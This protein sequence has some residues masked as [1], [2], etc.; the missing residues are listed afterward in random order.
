[1]ITIVPATSLDSATIAQLWNAKRLDT[2]SCWYQAEE[3]DSTYIEALLLAG[4][5]MAIAL[6]DDVPA[7]FGLWFASAGEARLVALAADDEAVYYRLM[8]E[9]CDWAQSLGAQE[10][11]AEIGTEPTSE[12]ARMDALAVIDYVPIG[13]APLLPGESLEQRVPVLLRAQCDLAV[14]KDAVTQILEPAP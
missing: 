12:K 5:A 13:F 3:V 1:M 2:A 14:L 11:F 9:F 10:G 7:G 4:F 6:A 8:G